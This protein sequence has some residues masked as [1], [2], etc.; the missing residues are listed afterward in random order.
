[1]RGPSY[2]LFAIRY[3]L[4]FRP[5][6][7]G[8]AGLALLVLMLCDRVGIVL[9]AGRLGMARRLQLLHRLRDDA[10]HLLLDLYDLVLQRRSEHGP[11]RLDMAGHGCLSVEH[12]AEALVGGLFEAARIVMD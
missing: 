1:M 9:Q 2:S 4:L 12:H 11:A 3:S 7:T 10:R 8:T 6:L 5:G